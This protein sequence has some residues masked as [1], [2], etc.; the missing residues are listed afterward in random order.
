[1]SEQI[2]N[3]FSSSHLDLEHFIPYQLSTLTETVSKSLSHIYAYRFG[4]TI[5]EWRVMAILGQYGQMTAKDIGEY[6]KMHKTKVSRAVHALLQ[7]AFIERH[8]NQDD[9][10]EA[11]LSLS[12]SGRIIYEQIIPDALSFAD[13]LIED[14]SND[15]KEKLNEFI[16]RLKQR[17]QMWSA[18]KKS[19]L[20][21]I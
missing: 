21:K 8:A 16:T 7:S 11:F 3:S 5:T 1:M 2:K 19:P 18:E 10:R 4:L 15:E 20:S 6:S 12:E 17:S 9:L 13:W 14:F